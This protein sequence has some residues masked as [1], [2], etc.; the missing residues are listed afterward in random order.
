L[1]TPAIRNTSRELT[2]SNLLAKNLALNL[3][4]FGA[5]LVV[6]V[7]AIPLLVKHMG[8]DRFGILT[9]AWV[10]IG[11]LSLLDMGLGRAL[12]KLVAEKLGSGLEETVPALIWTALVIMCSL[13][14]VIAV[15]AMALSPLLIKDVLNI[16]PELK[17]ET[18]LTFYLLSGSVPIVIISVAFRGILE[19]HQRFDIVNGIRIPLGIYSFLAPLAVLP[20]S[21]SLFFIVLILV[22]GK[23]VGLLIQFLF[24]LHVVPLLRDAITFKSSN[25]V[26]LF[27]FGSWMTVT[28][29][30]SP[31]L[32]YVDRFI[33]GSLIS[34][35][36]VA[37][38]ATPVE[39]VLKLLM[40]SGALTGVL[41]PAF[42][43]SFDMD[44]GRSEKLF[45]KGVKYVFL[46]I[47]PFS[48]LIVT[49]AFEGL[50]LWLGM[51]FS[52]HSTIVLQCSAV[53]V[54]LLCLGQVPYA[55]VQGAGRPD[56]TAKLHFIELIVYI[57]ILV[58]LTKTYGIN[59]V[60]LAWI[61]R[62]SIDMICM[63]YFSQKILNSKMMALKHQI[64]IGLGALFLLYIAS[65]LSD[66][67][68]K[69]VFFVV[70]VVA[71][72]AITW[73]FFLIPEEK[74]LLMFKST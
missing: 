45:R 61:L 64:G 36:A 17:H 39:M 67:I 23:L 10:V 59:G 74:K 53:G 49:F 6:A 32:I 42:S 41:F 73:K 51:E 58:L 28:N 30:I 24:C 16:P 27:K 12:T 4:G 55:M 63:Y 20:F 47:F 25:V 7:F 57:P 60:A 13:G 46:M 31:L 50:N 26:M 65:T 2:K 29:I 43:T 21:S 22:A 33:I 1:S 54:L 68:G 38:Y 62:V 56:L 72:I 18:I 34:V 48:L 40:I 15:I 52:E 11:Y 19:A 5:P 70:V 69:M 14:V 37:Y 35:T 66:T 9:L 71:L 3:I 44:P 8:V